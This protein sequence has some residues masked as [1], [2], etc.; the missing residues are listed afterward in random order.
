MRRYKP[1]IFSFRGGV[2]PEESAVSFLCNDFFG[3]PVQPAALFLQGRPPLS[4]ILVTIWT[5]KEYRILQPPFAITYSLPM[6]RPYRCRSVPRRKHGSVG[7][8]QYADWSREPRLAWEFHCTTTSTFSPVTVGNI[9]SFPR[10][11]LREFTLSG[12]R[13]GPYLGSVTPVQI[14]S[15]LKQ[16]YFQTA[17]FSGG[18]FTAATGA[19]APFGIPLGTTT[20]NSWPLKW[21]LNGN[22]P[23]TSALSSQAQQF[24]N[25]LTRLGTLVSKSVSCTSL[26]GGG[27]G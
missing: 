25:L 9:K 7:Y 19:L 26:F 23:G 1:F 6:A 16:L 21:G 4:L 8:F 14:G 12:P 15:G 24:G 2:S 27:K 22:L 5:A 10:T 13:Y 18:T 11:L 17:T 3:S 20:G